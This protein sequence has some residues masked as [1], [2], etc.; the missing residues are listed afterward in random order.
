[1]SEWLTQFE[2]CS[3]VNGWNVRKTVKLHMLLE[4]EALALWLDLSKK[5]RKTTKSPGKNW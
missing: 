2:I 4:G 3:K 1:M 5:S